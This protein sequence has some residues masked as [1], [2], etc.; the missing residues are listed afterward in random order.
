MGVPAG[1]WYQLVNLAVYLSSS[2]M[3]QDVC[4]Y[5]AQY[6]SNKSTEYV[7]CILHKREILRSW[8]VSDCPCHFRIC[9]LSVKAVVNALRRRT[10][11]AIRV[12]ARL[13]AV[14][15]AAVYYS[16]RLPVQSALRGRTAF[17]LSE[18]LWVYCS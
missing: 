5:A 18:H 10:A 6:A 12:H 17:M 8:L 4:Q 3:C 9:R 15:T 14:C 13:T 11:V 1:Y 7:M 2:S 16:S